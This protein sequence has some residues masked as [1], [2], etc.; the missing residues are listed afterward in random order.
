MN[1]QQPQEKIRKSTL[2]E[3]LAENQSIFDKKF[4]NRFSSCLNTAER[5]NLHTNKWEKIAELNLPRRALSAVAL[6]DGIY[7]LG[8][9]DGKNYLSS[10]EK[11]DETSNSWQYVS[12]M[13]YARCTLS[14][15]ATP[16]QNIYVL[17]GFD[18]GPLNTVEKYSVITDSWDVVNPMK[19]K[20]FM[21]AS[22]ITF[23]EG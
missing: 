2:L 20:R 14:A 12:S 16:D 3:A 4:I 7:A 11:Y 9:F 17:G 15:I 18:N 5:F 1:Q 10:V 23:T 19:Y 8:G 13:N 22:T 21:H 6:S